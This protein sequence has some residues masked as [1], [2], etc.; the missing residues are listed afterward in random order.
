MNEKSD[1]YEYFPEELPEKPPRTFFRN[2]P[3]IPGY[4]IPIRPHIIRT[5]RRI[6][7]PIPLSWRAGFER[8]YSS[9]VDNWWLW[10]LLSWVISALCMGTIALI[11]LLSDN[12]PVGS[13]DVTLNSIISVLSGV[14]KAALLLP[15]AEAL[16]QLKWSW[17]WRDT[18]KVEDFEAFDSASRGPWGSLML[19]LKTKGQ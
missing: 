19:L 6:K 12:R 13:N 2:V 4:E 11:L 15:T 3:F 8:L 5:T 14:A 18:K 9:W 10:E 17:F 1:H 16:G 7:N